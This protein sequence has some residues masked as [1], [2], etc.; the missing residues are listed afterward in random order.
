MPGCSTACISARV[1]ASFSVRHLLR[2]RPFAG[3][4]KNSAENPERLRLRFTPPRWTGDAAGA[5]QSAYFGMGA[6]PVIRAFAGSS[7]SIMLH[8]CALWLAATASPAVPAYRT[9]HRSPCARAQGCVLSAALPEEATPRPKAASLPRAGFSISIVNPA[10]AHIGVLVDKRQTVFA[11]YAR[12]GR[13]ALSA[14][15]HQ[16][17]E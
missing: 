5:H 3:S 12:A 2:H 11:R 13:F 15:H 14:N 6:G 16:C 9:Y 1:A 17:R 7:L 8:F 4:F 10:R